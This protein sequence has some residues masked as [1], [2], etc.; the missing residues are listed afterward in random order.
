[1]FYFQ[2]SDRGGSFSSGEIN[3]DEGSKK[4]SKSKKLYKHVAKLW[5]TWLPPKAVDSLEKG[6]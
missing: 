2:L 6:K 3:E 1:M 5:Q 4:L